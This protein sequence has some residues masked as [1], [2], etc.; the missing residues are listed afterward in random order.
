MN[1]TQLKNRLKKF[2]LLDPYPLPFQ[3]ENLIHS[4]ILVAFI[5]NTNDFSVLLTKRA[6]HLNQHA[7][8]ISFPGGR[9]DSTDTNVI[10]R[11]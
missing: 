2:Q 10:A 5:Q 6:D 1:A 9:V 7:G 4:A 8:Q 11:A 3:Q